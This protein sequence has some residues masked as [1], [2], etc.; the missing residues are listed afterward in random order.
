MV[1]LLISL[2]NKVKEISYNQGLIAD[3]VV[4]E[5]MNGIWTY[6]KWNSGMAEC[7]GAYNYPNTGGTR[8]LTLPFNMANADYVVFGNPAGNG[9]IVTK[10]GCYNGAGN[11]VNAVG[12]FYYSITVS[13]NYSV[14]MHFHVIGRWK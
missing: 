13:S 1:N 6:R 10:H 7:W 3:Y 9:S 11:N 4:E 8:Q 14:T 5:G 12:S 2:I